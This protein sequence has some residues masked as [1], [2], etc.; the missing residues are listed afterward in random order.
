MIGTLLLPRC[1]KGPHPDGGRPVVLFLARHHRRHGPRVSLS[2]LYSQ[3]ETGDVRPACSPSRTH[4]PAPFGRCSLGCSDILIPSRLNRIK[5]EPPVALRHSFYL[6]FSLPPASWLRPFPLPVLQRTDDLPCLRP[7]PETSPIYGQASGVP[8]PPPPPT[9]WSGRG[10]GGGRFEGVQLWA[11][12]GHR[13]GRDLTQALRKPQTQN[14]GHV[15]VFINRNLY[16]PSLNP[17]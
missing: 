16:H 6:S 4:P 7:T 14:V 17:A 11:A 3:N 2:R 9:V 5:T 12:R 15:P 13:E 8:S 1:H 10:G